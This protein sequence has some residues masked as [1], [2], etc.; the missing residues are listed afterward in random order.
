MSWLLFTRAAP[1]GLGNPICFPLW[2]GSLPS[3]PAGEV[4]LCLEP[5]LWFFFLVIL[6]YLI[7][8]PNPAAVASC[9]RHGPD[10]GI[11]RESIPVRAARF[12]LIHGGAKN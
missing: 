4:R 11:L 7:A 10:S 3:L 9:P 2:S 1:G 5:A 8:D 12:F 6:L